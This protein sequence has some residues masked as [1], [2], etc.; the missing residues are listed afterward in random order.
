MKTP[1]ILP[2]L[3]LILIGFTVASCDK[4]TIIRQSGE[5]SETVA[6][7]GGVKMNIAAS[8]NINPDSRGKAH[9]V[10]LKV[11]QL[12]NRHN[13]VNATYRELVKQDFIVLGDSL[14]RQSEVTVKPGQSLSLAL[15]QNLT[16]RYLG[17]V[18]LFDQ[19]NSENWR[20]ISAVTGNSVNITLDQNMIYVQ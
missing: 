5:V 15:D 14:V 7:K 12:S 8:S 3:L 17:V 16:G 13:F 18:A 6:R 1:R 10:R 4:T 11:Y 2:L 19:P 20:V 9:P